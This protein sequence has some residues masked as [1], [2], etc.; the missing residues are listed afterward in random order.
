VRDE[1]TGNALVEGVP[2]LLRLAQVG[3]DSSH[4]I[5]EEFL[6]VEGRI[7]GAIEEFFLGQGIGAGEGAAGAVQ[8]LQSDIISDLGMDESIHMQGANGD[9]EEAMR[10]GFLQGRDGGRAAGDIWGVV[11]SLSLITGVFIASGDGINKLGYD[12]LLL[13]GIEVIGN[14]GEEAAKGA[15]IIRLII[16]RE[17]VGSGF[18]ARDGDLFGTAADGGGGFGEIDHRIGAASEEKRAADEGEHPAFHGAG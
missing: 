2:D 10:R 13:G 14:A 16:L 18:D 17:D 6:D 3:E 8:D 15:Y 1:R 12:G 9:E 7:T 11:N 5:G 4:G